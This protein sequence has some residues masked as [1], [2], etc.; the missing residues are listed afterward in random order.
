MNSRFNASALVGSEAVQVPRMQR[1]QYPPARELRV[2]KLDGVDNAPCD[3][4][5]RETLILLNFYALRTCTESH[6]IA[7]CGCSPRANSGHSLATPMVRA[8]SHRLPSRADNERTAV[9]R[10]Q[11]LPPALSGTELQMTCRKNSPCV[12]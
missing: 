7:K 2:C 12:S 4:G 9:P 3:G 5:H 8:T 6:A 11:L 1:H 10:Q